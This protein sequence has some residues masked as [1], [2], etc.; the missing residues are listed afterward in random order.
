M[1]L[2]DLNRL[3]ASVIGTCSPNVVGAAEKKYFTLLLLVAVNFLQG[4]LCRK[5]TTR[6]FLQGRLRTYNET[7]VHQRASEII[8][9]SALCQPRDRPFRSF[10]KHM[11]WF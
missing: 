4:F 5:R 9:L 11:A 3:G 2:Q 10:K 6:H 7:N 1:K 8:M